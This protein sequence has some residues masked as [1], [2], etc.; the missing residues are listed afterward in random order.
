MQLRLKLIPPLSKLPKR[1]FT[2]LRTAISLCRTIA[3]AALAIALVL[4]TA[5]WAQQPA[6]TLKIDYFSNA[7]N[8][9]PLDATVRITNPGT[10]GGD[11]CANVYVFSPDQQLNECCSCL[12]TPDGLT[13]L[14]VKVDLTSNPLT[15]VRPTTGVFK[16]ISSAAG[17]CDAAHVTPVAG[18][19][20]W[21]THIQVPRVNLAAVTESAFSDATLSS[22]ELATV[23]SQCGF[24]QQVGSGHGICT[25]GTGG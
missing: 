2:M 15:R 10:S 25:C 12:L 13:T 1:I 8:G 9:V 23:T 5:A 14:S 21:A 3:F 4:S 11:L 17:S 24:I 6:D 19:R 20:A 18:I 16:I 22:E 7:N